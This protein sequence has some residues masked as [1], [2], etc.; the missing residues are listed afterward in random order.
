MRVAP[1]QELRYGRVSGG[2]RSLLKVR[3]LDSRKF[4]GPAP[5]GDPCPL[6]CKLQ[7]HSQL[8][9]QSLYSASTCGYPNDR[10]L[11]DFA[12]SASYTQMCCDF[13]FP[14]T[15]CQADFQVNGGAAWPAMQ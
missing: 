14:G 11:G 7:Q 8:R 5:A 15:T 9:A 3:R 4:V 2:A 10:R 1:E 12:A 13:S 6:F